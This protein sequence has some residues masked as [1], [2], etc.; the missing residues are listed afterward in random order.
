[1]V[2]ITSA[3]LKWAA[4]ATTHPSNRHRETAGLRRLATYVGLRVRTYV[5][6]CLFCRKFQETPTRTWLP[7]REVA[8]RTNRRC[9]RTGLTWRGAPGGLHSLRRMSVRMVPIHGDETPTSG[10]ASEARD[11]GRKTSHQNAEVSP[12]HE[13]ET[14]IFSPLGPYDAGCQSSG[15]ARRQWGAR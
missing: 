4:C 15:H 10:S 14:E 2:C 1:M 13:R 12:S 9:W 5:S 3:S 11:I 6:S 8:D 7:Q